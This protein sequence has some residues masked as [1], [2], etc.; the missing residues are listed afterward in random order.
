M[1]CADRGLINARLRARARIFPS[2]FFASTIYQS[3]LLRCRDVARQS[4][5]NKLSI[6]HVSNYF[7]FNRQKYRIS[8]K[9]KRGRKRE[10]RRRSLS[11]PLFHEYTCAS[12]VRIR[13]GTIFL[14]HKARGG[15]GGNTAREMRRCVEVGNRITRGGHV[16]KL[17]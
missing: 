17:A 6:V 11:P 4:P 15:G 1:P 16:E 3:P 8:K 10:G 14:A 2:S 9:E 12:K 13:K 7:I 5:R